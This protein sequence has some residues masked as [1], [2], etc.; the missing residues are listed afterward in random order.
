MDL[1][2]Q[3]MV[4][5]RP[6]PCSESSGSIAA[7]LQSAFSTI[8]LLLTMRV[9]KRHRGGRAAAKGCAACHETPEGPLELP[10]VVRASEEGVEN[11]AQLVVMPGS[12]RP[13]F[14]SQTVQR[15]PIA[16]PH[17]CSHVQSNTTH[18]V[19]AG[20]PRDAWPMGLSRADRVGKAQANLQEN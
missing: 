19:S 8:Y 6:K 16:T 14:H 9:A 20:W 4:D 7:V 2:C 10:D 1:G 18:N 5:H 3:P 15:G 11:L 17:V 12:G 13:G